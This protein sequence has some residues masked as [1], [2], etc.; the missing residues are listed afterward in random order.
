MFKITDITDP[1]FLKS[2]SNSELDALCQ[3]IRDFLIDSLSKT[4]GH[5]GPNLGVVELTVAM[6][7]AFNSP[8]DKFIFDVGHQAYTHKILTGRAKDFPGL[9]MYKGLS[10]FPKRSESEHDVWE[11]GHSSTSISAAAGFVYARDYRNEDYHVVG[12]IGDGALTGGMAFEALNHLGEANKRVIIVLND[13][14]M[15]ISENVGA[16]TNLLNKMRLN[17][18]Y[19]KAKKMYINILNKEK[20]VFSLAKRVRDGVK[21]FFLHNNIFED[22]GFEYFGPFDG[23][24]IPALTNAFESAKTINKPVLIHV[25]T[26]KGKGYLPAQTDVIGKWHG[27]GPFDIKT[28][29]FLSKTSENQMNWSRIISEIV[30]KLAHDD[31]RIVTITPAMKSGSCLDVFE[32][33]HPDRL[34]DVGIA[35]QHAVTFAGGLV[36]NGMKPFLSIYST[37]LQR[38]YDQ[39]SHDLAR[40]NLPVVIGID[41][42]GLVNGDGDTHQ[43]IYDIAMT[44]HIPNVHLMMPRDAYEA[45]DMLYTA[46]LLNRL[47]LIRYPRGTSDVTHLS[48]YEPKQIEFG[49]WTKENFGDELILISY[50]PSVDYLKSIVLKHDLKAT[51]VNA[52]FLKPIDEAMLKELIGQNKPIIVF[53]EA[54]KIGSLNSAILEFIQKESLQANVYSLAIDDQYVDQGDSK[55]IYKDIALDEASILEL[56]KRIKK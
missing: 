33:A 16:F 27:C 11:T 20:H 53:E 52:R 49:T 24:D 51:L 18:K 36:A 14:K 13:N 3:D 23:H 43:G 44:R 2:L 54:I 12:V 26:Q 39:L 1:Q 4:G 28:G 15:S 6:H 10:G 37:F 45:Y 31:K 22:M 25:I 56:I 46:F 32:A 17:R 41:R 34:I 35:E 38:A 40:Q 55:E 48:T 47:S 9:R 21:S 8:R 19:N 30:T 29:D 42:A 5:V 50:G 7:R